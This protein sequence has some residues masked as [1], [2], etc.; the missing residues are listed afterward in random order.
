MKGKLLDSHH[1]HYQL[2]KLTQPIESIQERDVDLILL[3]EL[4]VNPDFAHWIILKLNLP[5]ATTLNGSWRSISEFGLGETDILFSYQSSKNRIFILIENKL[6]ASFQDAQATRYERRAQQYNE[7]G[8]CHQAY[9]LLIAPESYCNNQRD[10][11]TFLT[12][13]SIIDFFNE[14]QT[15]RSFYKANLLHIACEKLRRGYQPINDSTVQNFWLAYWEYIQ[16]NHPSLEMKRPTIVPFNSD[17]PMI[18]SKDLSNVVF[19]H[20]MSN[21]YT[22]AGF[23]YEIP[24]V[25]K[26]STIL[27]KEMVIERHKKSFSI[28]MVT[29]PIDRTQPFRLQIDR[30]AIAL[31]NIENMRNWIDHHWSIIFSRHH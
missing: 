4:N 3:E 17:W 9:S 30:I 7:N 26:L 24:D 10:F 27:P 15:K 29:P 25:E 16:K 6:D 22:D 1:N 12:Y 14:Q 2:Q 5:T 23:Q 11:A 8:Q 19:Y 13:E 18:F 20:K 31:K 21:G 28:R